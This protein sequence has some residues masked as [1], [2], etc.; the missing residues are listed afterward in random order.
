MLAARASRRLLVGSRPPWQRAVAW[1]AAACFVAGCAAGGDAGAPTAPQLRPGGRAE[2]LLIV[3]CLLPPQIRRLGEQVTYATARRAVKTAARDCEI[4][5]GEYVA[6]D[7]ANY[8]TALRVWLPLAESGD[9]AAQTYVG[10]IFEKGLGVPPDHAAAAVWYR[11]AAQRGYSRAAINLGQLYEQGL[12]VPKDPAQALGWYRKAAGLGD[13]PFGVAAPPTPAPQPPTQEIQQLRAEV[14]QLRGQLEAKQAELDRTQRQLEELRKGI[15]Q[16][17]GETE[18]ERGALGRLRQELADSRAREQAAS[19]RLR[20]LERTVPAREAQLAVRDR[21]LAGLRA[22]LAQSEAAATPRQ[23]E[24]ERLQRDS[25]AEL[26]RA[27]RDLEALRGTLAARRT[28]AEGDRDALARLRRE[29]EAARGQERTSSGRLRDLEQ[30]VAEREA[31]LA[32]RDRDVANLRARLTASETASAA[33]KADLE[34]LQKASAAELARAQRDL[35]ALR[36][37]LADRGREADAERSAVARMREDLAASRRAEQ[38]ATARQ[39]ELERAVADGEGRLAVKDRE[40]AELRTRLTRSEKDLTA[41]RAEFGRLQ[42]AAAARS[43]TAA[44]K[45]ASSGPAGARTVGLPRPKGAIVFGSYHALVIGNDDYR[46]LPR[47]QTAVNDARAL[48]RILTDSYGFKVTLLL[49]AGRYQILS[50]LNGLRERLTEKDN[51]LIYYAGHGEIDRKNQRGH[52]LPVDAEPNSSANWISN[53]AITDILNAMNVQQLL[54]VADSCYAGT[55]TRSSV[56]RI[57][58]G[59]SETERFKVIQLMAQKRSR[60][61]MTSGGVEPVLDSAGGPHSAFA[62]PFI[63]LLQTNVG[64]LSGQEMFRLLQLRVAATAQRLDV[65]QVPEYAPIKFAGHEAGDFFFVRASN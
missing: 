18:T 8:A 46:Q 28:D 9:P 5:G 17:R 54:V 59:L 13:L 40:L 24:L 3:D 7:R 45:E 51:F 50:A 52:W 34:R 62:Q 55:L 44:A 42:G 60:M 64:V 38:A 57:E 20:E 2:D 61:V 56:G 58:P 36:Q 16:R 33:K 35:A 12:G 26:A 49:N 21:E 11:R 29:L 14:A 37:A 48:A 41:L 31:Q 63:E 22:R 47:L 27:Q 15:E 4:R 19:G 1:A 23:A 6:F 10:E 53:I 25:V 30:A 65:Q 39:R 32:A 43:T